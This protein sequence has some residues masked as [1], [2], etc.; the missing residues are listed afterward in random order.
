MNSW[1]IVIALNGV[2]KQCHQSVT[3][4]IQKNEL[5]MGISDMN[6][7]DAATLVENNY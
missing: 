2:C 4:L 1:M 6:V 7:K 3:V 5:Q